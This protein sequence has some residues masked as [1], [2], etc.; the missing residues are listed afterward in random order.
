MKQKS[1]GKRLVLNRETVRLLTTG[2]LGGVAGGSRSTDPAC[3]GSEDTDCASCIPTGP[4]QLGL[5]G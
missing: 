1:A 3:T 5:Q 4:H 2:E